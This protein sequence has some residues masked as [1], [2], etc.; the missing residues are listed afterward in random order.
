MR[1]VSLVPASTEWVAALGAAANLVGRSHAC[2][3]PKE[4]V[5][6]PPVTKSAIHDGTPEEIDAAVRSLVESGEPP[7]ELNA[8]LL[9][10]L[11]PDVILTQDQC[12][13]CSISV[14]QL[15]NV[16]GG[17]TG[18]AP[19]LFTM[20]PDTFKDVLDAALRLGRMIGRTR[21]AMNFIAAKE[22][23]LRNLQA[24]LRGESPTS[25]VCLEWIDP[26]MTAGHW[27]P[28]LVEL[29]GG[30]ALL[31][32]GGN[33]AA[34]VEWSDVVAADPDVL[35]VMACGR[36][37]Q[38]TIRDL[39]ESAQRR[40]WNQLRAV[41]EGRV[42]AFDGNAYFS[43]PGPRLYRAIELLAMILHPRSVSGSIES[44]EMEPVRSA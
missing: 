33:P 15:Q 2:D 4:I 24:A 12:S 34:R 11:Q 43:R 23:R 14:D 20:R 1:I 40:D 41:R 18:E 32:V 16:I 9:V 29:A 25:I 42:F 44:W 21:E 37:T 3:H 39:R 27:T 6:V 36:T 31:A 22:R 38:D 28:N 30:R 19:E 5:D 35:A 8:E 10:Q 17:W 13:V 7:V 26:P